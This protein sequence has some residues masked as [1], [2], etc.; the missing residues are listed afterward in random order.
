M[1]K[2]KTTTS[3]N[4]P[5]AE[6]PQP[7]LERVVNQR[8]EWWAT[9]SIDFV[10]QL[11]LIILVLVAYA[12]TLGHGYVFDDFPTIVQN[13]FVKQG[14]GGI[15]EIFSTRLW[16]GYD[17]S[18][19]IQSYRPVTL[20]SFALEHQVAGL[21]PMLSH[22]V[23]VLIYLASVLLIYRLFR[24][25]I[26]QEKSL[27][28]LLV[29]FFFALHPIHTEPVNNLKS[30]D[31]L[32]ALAFGLAAL[33]YYLRYCLDG[34]LL[35]AGWAGMCYLLA[36]LSKETPITFLALAPTLGL[37]FKLKPWATLL[38]RMWPLALAAAIFLLLRHLVIS[39]HSTGSQAFTYFDQPML[40]ANTWSLSLGTKLW[41]FGK[42]LSLLVFPHP[43]T[44]SYFYNDIPIVPIYNFFALFSLFTILGL[45]WFTYHGWRRG[46]LYGLG[47]ATFFV[48]FSLFSHFIIPMG[49][50]MGERL[51]LTP[52]LGACIVFAD[53][54]NRLLAPF[55]SRLGINDYFRQKETGLILFT[56]IAF[57]C[58]A[59]INGRNLVWQ[60]NFTLAS[61]DV[62]T[63]PNSYILTR[64]AAL[65]YEKAAQQS[66][67]VFAR[68]SMNSHASRYFKK[69]LEIDSTNID[70]HKRYI[71]H[72]FQN[73]LLDEALK[74]CAGAASAKG[75][76][77]GE[78][79]ITRAK[80]YINQGAYE[81]ASRSIMAI[82]P[83]GLTKVLKVD[84]F[85]QAGILS[86][87]LKNYQEAIQNFQGAYS[88]AETPNEQAFVLNQV[89]NTYM[90]AEQL[91]E[92][93]KYYQQA[94]STLPS[95]AEPFHSLGIIA[96]KQGKIGQAI[97]YFTQATKVN[98][99]YALA[100]KN[101]AL[102]YQANGDQASYQYYMNIFNQLNQ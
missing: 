98:P 46:Q 42:N 18:E 38:K 99:R 70:L 56:C 7:V 35:A 60:N 55:P 15:P 25:L 29:A 72:L 52:S 83:E 78:I 28:P 1:K 95:F 13:K 57:V 90:M 69:A 26:S 9:Q 20:L 11:S 92:A 37:F 82:K 102:A 86:T 68:R 67:G 3:L 79:N 84:L 77:Q 39:A 74:A 45:L 22:L 8:K 49:N 34:K 40:L 91:A 63:S 30:R 85:V 61:N 10:S 59:K 33:W 27:T 43:L 53:L 64:Q 48:T 19:N 89:G 62:V 41:V 54:A 71:N 96:Y 2:K 50:A 93:Q 81:Q 31:E 14:L 88:F 65:E 97:N 51:L 58:L 76:D 16:D 87:Y 4:K 100:H 47:L 66:I 94:A 73:G 44:S 5:T 80:I 32:L 75:A 36:L 101:L 17:A 23:N 21:S 6:P 12:N 24:L